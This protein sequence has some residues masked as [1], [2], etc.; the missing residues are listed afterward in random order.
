MAGSTVRSW[1]VYC[2]GCVVSMPLLMQYTFTVPLR[3]RGPLCS[4]QRA[5]AQACACLRT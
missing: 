3:M 1:C 5:H 2:C 4:E